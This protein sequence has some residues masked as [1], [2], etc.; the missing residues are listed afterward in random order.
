MDKLSA[1]LSALAEKGPMSERQLVQELRE[2]VGYTPCGQKIT[3]KQLAA[4]LGIGNAYMSDILNGKR[5]LGCTVA[6]G[7]GFQRVVTFH[8]TSALQEK[9]L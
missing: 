6:N 7:I 9:D 3:A 4:H 5:G 1:R 8:P 2:I